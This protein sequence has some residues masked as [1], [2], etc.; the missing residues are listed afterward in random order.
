MTNKTASRMT[1][2]QLADRMVDSSQDK[3][4]TVTQLRRFASEDWIHSSGERDGLKRLFDES[5]LAAA[6]VLSE[7]TD[8]GFKDQGVMGAAALGM[9]AWFKEARAKDRSPMGY[10]VE[11]FLNGVGYWQFEMAF[12]RHDQTGQRFIQSF[13]YNVDDP[14]PEM[15]HAQHPGEDT[16][17]VPRGGVL[18]PLNPLFEH[19]FS[20]RA[21]A[22]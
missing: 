18:I 5:A 14:N 8:F 13:V 19:L 21:K 11:H 6:K 16:G 9:N 22:N 17:Y 12:Y 15:R 3:Y 2:G 7:L 20:D 1:I 10:A 4:Q